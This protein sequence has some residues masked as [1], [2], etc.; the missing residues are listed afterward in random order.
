MA[1]V[2][3]IIGYIVS[4]AIGGFVIYPVWRWMWRI[5]SPEEPETSLKTPNALAIFQGCIERALYT[6]TIILGR[7][8]GIAV[9]LAFKA[10][11]RVHVNLSDTRHVPGSSIYLVGT[12]LSVAF[13]VAG[14]L[15]AKLTTTL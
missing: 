3:I 11:M 14:G 4:V 8:E 5:A 12:A 7:P 1:P 10:I 6:S 15:I 13:G 2:S 9:W